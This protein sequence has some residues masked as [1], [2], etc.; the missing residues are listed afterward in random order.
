MDHKAWCNC[1]LCE[2]ARRMKPKRKLPRFVIEQYKQKL[3]IKE[4]EMLRSGF[5]LMDCPYCGHTS[6]SKIGPIMK[7]G[8]CCKEIK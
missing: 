4:D 2:T 6:W 7:C 3:L 5:I 8:C 1:E